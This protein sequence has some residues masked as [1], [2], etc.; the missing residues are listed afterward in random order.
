[1]KFFVG[2]FYRNSKNLGLWKCVASTENG[3]NGFFK[4]LDEENSKIVG[5]FISSDDGIWSI[6]EKDEIPDRF[7]F[8]D[9]E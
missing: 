5:D 7:Y 6:V 2:A 1:M 9:E 4:K 3:K 8:A